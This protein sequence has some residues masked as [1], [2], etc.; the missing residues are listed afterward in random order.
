[1]QDSQQK[2]EDLLLPPYPRPAVDVAFLVDE[3]SPK[4]LSRPLSLPKGRAVK[5][6][7]LCQGDEV[8]EEAD[9]TK[10]VIESKQGYEEAG[11]RLGESGWRRAS[12]CWKRVRRV[13]GCSSACCKGRVSSGKCGSVL[14]VH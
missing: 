3:Q 1:M 5:R 2:R 7:A 6:L 4:H 14:S 9:R 8:E 12:V 13:G 11:R 10:D